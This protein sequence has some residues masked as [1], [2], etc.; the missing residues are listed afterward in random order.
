MVP[1]HSRHW[2]GF[3]WSS[4]TMESAPGS[5]DAAWS[6][7]CSHNIRCHVFYENEFLDSI[8]LPLKQSFT[9]DDNRAS[10]S[11]SKWNL[12]KNDI[13]IKDNSYC[14]RSHRNY[15]RNLKCTF[16]KIMLKKVPQT[17]KKYLPGKITIVIFHSFN[18]GLL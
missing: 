11:N 10:Q 16:K 17:R 3:G 7:L 9:E 6:A 5:T 12:G 2:A 18:T 13:W 4:W 15:K 14:K 1:S 8:F